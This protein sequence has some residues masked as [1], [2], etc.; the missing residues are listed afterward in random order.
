MTKFRTIITSAL[1]A[2]L[3]VSTSLADTPEPTQAIEADDN[4]QLPD[5]LQAGW[6]G[7]PVCENLFEND[8]NRILRCNF[9]PGGGHVRH[10]HR[11]HFGY[12]IS[13]GQMR[14]TS[15][16]G[17]REVDLKTGVSYSSDGVVWHEG[18]NIGTTTVTYL[19]VEQK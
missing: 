8:Q 3:M 7:V 18:L 12:A 16:D 13:G 14:L 2:I 1:M 19:I 17:V 11:P 9:P 4:T 6:N 10:F 5:P 15:A